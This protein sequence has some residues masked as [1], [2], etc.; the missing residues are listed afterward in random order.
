MD[1]IK[2]QTLI[3]ADGTKVEAKTALADKDLTLIYFSAKWCPRMAGFMPKLKEFYEKVAKEGVEVIYVSWDNSSEDMLNYM[4][5]SHGDWLALQHDSD[6][7]D[8]LCTYNMSKKRM[9]VQKLFKCSTCDMDDDGYCICET[10]IKTCHE[11]HETTMSHEERDGFGYGFCDCGDE[12]VSGARTCKT[13]KQT[14]DNSSNVREQ[15]E[16]KFGLDDI[17]TLLVLKADGTLVTDNAIEDIMEEEALDLVQEWKEYSAESNQ[18]PNIIK[19]SNVIKADESSKPVEEVLAGKDLVLIYF[20]AHWCPPCRRFTP[21]LKKF[22]EE[23]VDKGIE[24]IFVSW[25]RSSEDM[26][27]YMKEAHGD[28]YAFEHES[29]VGKKLKKKFNVDGIPSLV[30]L[31]PDGTV[32]TESAVQDVAEEDSSEVVKEW[33]EFGT[34]ANEFGEIIKGSSLVKADRSTK[35]VDEALAGKDVILIY[36]SA[37]W[38]PPCRGFTPKLK[39]FYEQNAEKGIEIIFVSW[40][41]S[42]EDMFSYM[43]EAHGDWYAL[44]HESKVGKKL[45][46]KFG[47]SGIPCLVALKA[48]GTIIDKNARGSIEKPSIVSEWKSA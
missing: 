30:V 42:S 37:H 9:V 10:C 47:V 43:E 26:L 29:K 19:G 41:R 13:L 16:E 1:L 4:K 28:W 5:E 8:A 27:N 31:K 40:D 15:L 21:M 48:D 36:F 11:G 2:S 38:C 35:P 7:S 24:L 3:K 23:N 25:D 22:Y 17:P 20:S 32:I 46:K 12:A 18:F 39:E 44:E 6:G 45:K 34:K 33:K 14:S